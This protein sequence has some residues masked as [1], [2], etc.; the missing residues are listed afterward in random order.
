MFSYSF[1][2]DSPQDFLVS[3]VNR[4]RFCFFNPNQGFLFLKWQRKEK[5]GIYLTYRCLIAIFYTFC[6]AFSILHNIDRGRFHVYFIY[7][8]NLNLCGSMATAVL[9]A[10]S[11]ILHHYDVIKVD[12]K[13]PRMLK[14]YW[15]LWNQ[16]TVIS[17]V[18]TIFYWMMLH[19]GSEIS[20][21]NIFVH[22]TNSAVLVFDSLAVKHPPRY[23]LCVHLIT[24]EIAYGV[25]TVI[26]QMLGG[27]DK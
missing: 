9:G 3:Q 8:T 21:N 17:C 22:V 14:I 12:K 5:C 27:L 11:V 26:Y 25:F 24:V 2:H 1:T 16:S 18:V 13:M 20:L 6:V 19:N 7:L 15:A 23:S 10:M 4:A